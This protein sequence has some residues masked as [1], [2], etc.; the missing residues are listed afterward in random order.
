MLTIERVTI[1]SLHVFKA[2]RLQALQ[3]SPQAFGSTYA[4]EVQLPDSTGENGPARCMR[5]LH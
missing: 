5:G 3:E 4:A 2:V 1:D